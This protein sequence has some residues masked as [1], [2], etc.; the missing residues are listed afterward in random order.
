MATGKIKRE[1]L[2]Q[3]Q[4][5]TWRDRKFVIAPA[6]DWMLDFLHFV[7]REQLTLALESV[8]GA[9]QYEEFRTSQPRPKMT[10]LQGLLG[11]IT[12][13]FGVDVGEA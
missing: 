11:S 13:A 10:E 9:E 12:S 7:D 3:E 1:A 8:L 2:Q 5:I 6:D 4:H